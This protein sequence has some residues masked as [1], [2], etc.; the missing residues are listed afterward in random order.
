[1]AEIHPGF[2]PETG[3]WFWQRY[4]GK[5]IR[6]LCAK[7]GPGTTAIDYY[8]NGYRTAQLMT[9]ERPAPELEPIRSAALRIMS[10]S[11]PSPL[12]PMQKP[13]AIHKDRKKPV[14]PVYGSKEWPQSDIDKLE[15]LATKGYSLSQIA[16]VLKR[17]RNS[18]AGKA[19]RLGIKLS[20]NPGPRCR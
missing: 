6:A 3:T 11:K 5:T 19:S 18:I 2:D 15:E 1:M 12:P 16:K 4:E 14:S 13:I 9:K 10:T 8:P 17:T 20:G 7:I